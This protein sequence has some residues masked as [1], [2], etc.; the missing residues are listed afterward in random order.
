MRFKKLNPF[1]IWFY[2]RTG[3]GTYLVFFIAV[4]NVM[5]TTYYLAIENISA[6]KSIFPTF[7]EWAIFI[8]SIGLPLSTLL[9]YW[10]FKRS[11]A[12]R[13]E[14]DIDVEINPY[15][16]KLP[17]KGF[18]AEILVPMFLETVKM[19]TK[20]LKKEAITEAEL[21]RIMKLQKKAELLIEG[22]SVLDIE[23]KLEHKDTRN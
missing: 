16:Y 23:S 10:H 12:R 3:Y 2:F 8:I 19:N 20:L 14:I 7:S 21:K 13:S 1:R 5:V 11:K 15:V 22:Y 18:Y 4:S 6:L 9:G 17:P